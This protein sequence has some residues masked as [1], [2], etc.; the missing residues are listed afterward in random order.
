MTRASLANHYSRWSIA[1]HWLMAVLLVATA[2]TIELKG[3]YPKGSAGRDLLKSVHFMLGLSVFGLVWLRLLA[4]AMGST[5]AIVPPPPAWQA[6]LGRLVHLALYAL[7]IGLPLLGWLTL[8]AK[9]AAVALP[10]GFALPLLPIAQS[11]AT[12]RWIKDLH[13]TGATVGYGLVA[14]HVA[15]ALVHHYVQRDNTLSHMLPGTR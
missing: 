7:M 9:G 4:R 14:L 1:L 8:S 3:V 15:A 13:E 11:D 12:S 10:G 6:L 2:A 5:P